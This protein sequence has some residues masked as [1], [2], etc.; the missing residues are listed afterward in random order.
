MSPEAHLTS[1]SW[2]PLGLICT[3]VVV[4]AIYLRGWLHLRSTFPRLIP[5]SRL[6]A[7]IGGLLTIWIAVGSPLGVLDRAVLSGH[8]LQHL[9]LMTVAP[10]LLLIG[11]PVVASMHGLPRAVSRAGRFVLSWSWMRSLGRVLSHPAICLLAASVTLMVWHVPAA[12]E[13]ALHSVSWHMVARASFFVAGILLWW[14]VIQPWPTI[15]KWPRWFIPGYLFLVT[16]PCDALSA[17]LT[18]YDRIVYSSY[19]SAPTVFGRT[20]LEDQQFAGALM[21]LCVT[22]IYM[23]PAAVI[24]IQILSPPRHARAASV[25]RADNTSL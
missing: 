3:L 23:V 9:L 18:F 21:W 4:A 20:P 6:A 16:L 2:S 11:A 10:P 25:T 14:P 17:F 7:F 1:H 15:V 22:V 8:M 19:R 5:I 24:T 13:L 12:F